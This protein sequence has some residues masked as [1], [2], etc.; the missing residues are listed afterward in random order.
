MTEKLINR[1]YLVRQYQNFIHEMKN[2]LT[3]RLADLDTLDHSTLVSAINEVLSYMEAMAGVTDTT[4]ADFI[5]NT[6]YY[7]E[8]DVDAK[9]CFKAYRITDLF[10][11]TNGMTYQPGT[12]FYA[13]TH[14]HIT[15]PIDREVYDWK[16]LSNEAGLIGKMG[17]IDGR[18]KEYDLVNTINHMMVDLEVTIEAE[19]GADDILKRYTMWQGVDEDTRVKVAEIDIPKD[20]VVTEGRVITAN[21]PIVIGKDE[22]GFDIMAILGEKYLELTIANQEQ[23]VF[24]L[25]KD[26]VDVYTAEENAAKVQL[27]ISDINEISAT[28]VEKSIEKGDLV[29]PVQRVL[30][31][32]GYDEDAPVQLTTVA[33]TLREAV[34]EIDAKQGD[35]IL[36]TSA[37]TLSGA[38]AEHEVK[39]GEM[40]NLRTAEKNSLVGVANELLSGIEQNAE[41]IL[42]RLH[43]IATADYSDF[44]ASYRDDPAITANSTVIILD[45]F[46]VGGVEYKPGTWA[47]LFD[48]GTTK[49]WRYMNNG[50]GGDDIYVEVTALPEDN[51]ASQIADIKTNA[52]YVVKTDG[53]ASNTYVYLKRSD[54]DRTQNE[55]LLISSDSKGI[56]W[57]GSYNY[58]ATETIIDPDTGVS[59]THVIP[60]EATAEQLA[61]I[62]NW[63]LAEYGRAPEMN[64]LVT[65]TVD[66]AY[67][68]QYL[69]RNGTWME[70]SSLT[71]AT[72]AQYGVAIFS[73]LDQYDKGAT[74]VAVDPWLLKQILNG[75]LDDYYNKAETDDLLD[76]KVSYDYLVDQFYDKNSVDT[77]LK[78]LQKAY[79]VTESP[80][81]MDAIKLEKYY[82]SLVYYRDGATG[83]TQTFIIDSTGVIENLGDSGVSLDGYV[84]TTDPK[85]LTLRDIK[86]ID[87]TGNPLTVQQQL[88]KKLEAATGAVTTVMDTNLIVNRAVISNS[89]G[90]I[91]AS[92]ITA[93]ELEMLTGINTTD[94]ANRSIEKRLQALEAGGTGT[95]TISPIAF[96]TELPAAYN[97]DLYTI[98]RLTVNKNGYAPGYYAWTGAT[99]LRLDN[100]GAIEEVVTLPET[101]DPNTIYKRITDY[102]VWVWTNATL[103]WKQLGDTAGGGALMAYINGV[104]VGGYQTSEQLK[105][106]RE[107][108]F[109][110]YNALSAVEQANGT[111][112]FITDDN[113]G[114]SG[115]VSPDGTTVNVI[116]ALNS[117]SGTDALSA[118]QGRI[119]K[120]RLDLFETQ[121]VFGVEDNLTSTDDKVALSANQGR[122][123]KEMI[124]NVAGG[125]AAINIANNLTTTG[126]GS[127][128]DATQGRELK[129]LIDNQA[130]DISSLTTTINNL[131]SR[132]KTLE[133]MLAAMF[134]YDSVNKILTIKKQ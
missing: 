53:G 83:A 129:R 9:V 85:Y 27:A 80:E 39:I 69:F 3:G 131:T 70:Y 21:G 31:F 94:P 118:N 124:N 19:A 110:E 13:T 22:D 18:V 127:A 81:T 71:K 38:I 107:L 126:A 49:E 40:A 54:T 120:S 93:N 29:E 108:T 98:Y 88:D 102:T 77:K 15:S 115:A 7:Q 134:D 51:S 43:L 121:A 24:I 37:Q 65:L 84:P 103:K 72:K 90:K 35:E 82:G 119:L 25:V 92:T 62:S 42:R 75:L 109:A 4:Y 122:V 36:P 133:D 76:E 2:N 73:T 116:D 6:N 66:R 12:I 17:E 64:D 112:Y 23:H 74:N 106:V 41:D 34:N 114:G 104:Q 132:V 44:V 89:L 10:E 28:I 52:I 123:L 117:Y 101:G 130:T 56:E 86:L 16:I 26:L 1:P 78:A 55:W 67:F 128:L 100:I 14:S 48:N 46:E 20:L 125:G 91:A 50:G 60:W 5:T 11:H 96:V 97:A 68:G 111:V 61:G 99:Y 95:G 113:T 105:I 63:V 59:T 58:T 57:I 47:Y 87:A 30:D 33:Q 79:V 45:A 8:A 32:A